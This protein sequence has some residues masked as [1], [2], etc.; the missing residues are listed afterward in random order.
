VLVLA[1]LVPAAA[2]GDFKGLIVKW[3]SVLRIADCESDYNPS[4]VRAFVV[5]G[6]R[7]T[8]LFQHLPIYWCGRA[9]RYGVPGASIF[10]ADAQAHVTA[11]MF[12][13]GQSG[14]LQCK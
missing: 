9:A 2:A 10:D 14:L 3:A 12:R 13:D 4:A 7:L 11:G 1:Q 6:V 5:E 8:G